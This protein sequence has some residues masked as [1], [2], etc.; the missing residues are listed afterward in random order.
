MLR[1][2][3]MCSEIR[4]LYFFNEKEVYK[5]IRDTGGSKENFLI[6]KIENY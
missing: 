5:G 2:K 3:E 1:I 4:Q 6:L